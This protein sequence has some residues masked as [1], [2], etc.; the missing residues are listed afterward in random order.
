MLLPLLYSIMRKCRSPSSCIG[1]SA[2]VFALT[3]VRFLPQKLQHCALF[4][5]LGF[6][7]AVLMWLIVIPAH[8]FM[9][10]LSSSL[11]SLHI[12]KYAPTP[13]LLLH[14]LPRFPSSLLQTQSSITGTLVAILCPCLM[15]VGCSQICLFSK[16]RP[17]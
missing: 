14:P 8:S 16:Q 13:V 4:V 11:S 17:R 2:H 9:Q 7:S 12:S 15:L 3:S 5:S 6:P 10:T 1:M